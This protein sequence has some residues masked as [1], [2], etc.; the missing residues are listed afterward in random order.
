MTVKDLM[1]I[2]G[3][4]ECNIVAGHR[5]VQNKI[6]SVTTLEVP[7]IVK[8]LKGNEL[9]LS[10]LYPI[11]DNEEVQKDLI[12]QLHETGTAALAI[13]P[14]TFVKKIPQ[15]FLEEAE[16]YGL[17]IIEIPKHITY[18]DIIAPVMNAIFDK[19]VVLQQDLEQASQL[20]N[21]ISLSA[22]GISVFI[23]TLSHL[24]KNRITVESRLSYMEIPKADFSFS[25]LT[26][27][28]KRSLS[29]VKRPIHFIRKYEN[30]EVDCI[31]A[32]ILI[33]GEVYG[34]ITSWGVNS[35]YLEI[36]LAI[37]EKASTLLAFEF[38][39]SK[40]KFDTEQQYKNDFLRDIFL[41]KS[42]S[43]ELLHERG[44]KYNLNLNL[45][46]LCIT[47]NINLG[48]GGRNDVLLDKINKAVLQSHK[49]AIVGYF[50]DITYILLP[51]QETNE[52]TVRKQVESLYN[53]LAKTIGIKG[54][55]M[56][57][58][59][60]YE[61]IE[62]IRGSFHEAEKALYLG[63]VV[64]N[65]HNVIFFNDLGVYRLLEQLTDFNELKKI[66]LEAVGKLVEYDQH[67]DLDL[68]NTLRVYFEQNEKMKDTSEQLFIHVNT[69]KY[70]I[71]RINLIT[72]YRLNESE[73]KFI[74]HLG[75]KIYDF[76]NSDYRF[77]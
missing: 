77:R 22:Q 38:L 48:L 47:F 34:N 13:K 39:K 28:Q 71:S 26:F 63:K 33:E 7:E 15:H 27:D 5:G 24:T 25:P 12:R 67:H 62:G 60:I 42:I 30:E 37:L 19:K 75:L 50:R 44:K 41:N 18:L 70:R 55:K 11:K 59:R 23:K 10:T 2:G 35:E 76:M 17:P 73:G 14:H 52:A 40:V 43:L 66:Y 46:Y 6:E 56:G 1:R 16:K 31:V 61:G 4:R 36:D 69:L 3:L 53:K 9:L 32:P 8:W 54:V 74:L 68:V 21:E 64:W 29:V 49:D 45:S 57:V 20:L 51:V 65:Q 58:G 72:G